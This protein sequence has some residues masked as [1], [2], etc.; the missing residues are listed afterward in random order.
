MNERFDVG[1]AVRTMRRWSA[2]NQRSARRTLPLIL[3]LT[4]TTA[5]RAGD[6]AAFRQVATIPLTDI[7]GRIDH[8]T[9]DPAGGR[10]FVAAL[11]NNTVEVIDLATH[12]VTHHLGGM[13]E[14]QGV[15]FIPET[16]T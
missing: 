11:G 4:I 14:P 15:A 2:R 6:V 5:T 16:K 8:M 3:L 9:L 12:K 13:K 7:T 10:L 1:S